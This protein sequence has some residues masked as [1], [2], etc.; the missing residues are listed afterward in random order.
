LCAN[1]GSAATSDSQKIINSGWLLFVGEF[2]QEARSCIDLA[3]F[4][5]RATHFRPTF[6][7]STRGYLLLVPHRF[8]SSRFPAKLREWN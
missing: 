5:S 7:S 3:F 4:F 2:A 6:G 1:E 8:P